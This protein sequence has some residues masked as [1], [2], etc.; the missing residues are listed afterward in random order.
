MHWILNILLL[1][2]LARPLT[3]QV[4]GTWLSIHS[5]LFSAPN[6]MEDIQEDLHKQ[7]R[8]LIGKRNSSGEVVYTA[9][10]WQNFAKSLL[11][12][13]SLRSLSFEEAA[14]FNKAVT[15]A[16]LAEIERV[17]GL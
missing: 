10:Q 4:Q 13:V 14:R 15:L 11:S 5:L 17:E 2:S 9:I 12:P 3:D 1:N 7:L 16:V 8:R 6:Y